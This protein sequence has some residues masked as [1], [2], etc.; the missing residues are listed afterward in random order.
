MLKLQ[1]PVIASKDDL[2]CA[3]SKRRP[4]WYKANADDKK[5]YH[6]KLLQRLSA[7][8][9]PK[10][11]ACRNINCMDEEHSK[12]RDKFVLDILS[13]IIEVSHECIPLNN[14]KKLGST[15]Q[16]IPEWNS[17]IRPLKEDSLFWHSVWLSAGRPSTGGLHMVMCH[18][19]SKYH[20]AVKL[21]KREI[22]QRKNVEL[23]NA[24][25]LGNLEMLNEFKKSLCSKK[26]AQQLPDCVEGKV[27]HEDIL[28]QFKQRYEE[29]Y[30]S[31]DTS[32]E[33]TSIKEN[34]NDLI[35]SDSVK[36][37][38]KITSTIIK[39]G[40]RKMKSGKLDASGSYSS[41]VFHSA[42]DILFDFL[43]KVFQSY[44]VHGTVTAEILNC[45]FLPLFK[46]GFKNPEVFDSYRA[47][48]GASQLLKLLEYVILILWGDILKTDTMQFGFKSG[49]STTQCTWLVNEV[50]TYFMR[51]GTAVTACLLDCSKAF[52]KCRYD[53]LFE[54]LIEKGLPI[55]V[56]RVLIYIYQKQKGRV[57]LA[58]RES[59]L[60]NISN[61]TRQGSVLSPLL[62]SV[63]LDDLL[64]KLR[65]MSL[66]CHI[67]G[68]WVGAC[69][70][71]D[72]LILMAPSRDV[73]QNMLNV[74]QS[75]A[76]EH[77]LEFSTDPVPTKSKSKCIYFCGRLS[78]VTYPDPL[79]LAGKKL[80]W[81]LSA[82]H[83]GH[84]LSQKT[85]MEK[86]CQRARAKFIAKSTE[87]RE[88]L[89]FAQP[90]HVLR[91]IEVM[92]MDAY[93]SM[94]WNLE[95]DKA[96]QFFRSWN[97]CVKLVYN[98]PL[99]TFTY[100][101]EGYLASNLISMRNKV[102]AQYAG[103]FRS[104][105]GSPSKEVRAVA[106]IVS[107]D[108]RSTSCLNL[109][110]L[111]KR[112]GLKKPHEF[113]SYRIKSCLTMLKIPEAEEW[114]TGLLASLFNLRSEKLNRIEDTQHISA[115]IS[116]LCST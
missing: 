16:H 4:A 82:D 42:P 65:K 15:H 63:Y 66:G 104:L 86:D 84:T 22:R 28:D 109:R 68:F 25:E 12:S 50:T 10:S 73:L 111:T 97:T 23:S 74:C 11:I 33:M 9:T 83:L 47:I 106:K 18:V 54:K 62:F 93:G 46:G 21:A 35:S 49:V 102:L 59:E 31:A 77:N 40:S 61:G 7:L 5:Y 80:P 41:D 88:A 52:D 2:V 14:T 87:V 60:F 20:R 57:K 101:V 94:L 98:V 56:V 115:M 79:E 91:A 108:P 45:T 85:N 29:L 44:L 37:V 96:E 17:V 114:R 92:C 13:T 70:Y 67:K 6:D 76:I 95:S 36:E 38:E 32:I 48:A 78:R 75:Y 100:L 39:M 19:R 58:G 55:L 8:H 113:A 27:S 26:K 110:L 72:D 112:T 89:R 34:L 116:S 30:N 43:A 71:A 99:N 107:E 53:K 1:V 105:L 64:V 3:P 90:L 81:V 51:R 24:A 103:F 69:G